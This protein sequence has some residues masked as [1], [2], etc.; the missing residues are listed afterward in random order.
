MK[1]SAA[2]GVYDTGTYFLIAATL[3]QKKKYLKKSTDLFRFEV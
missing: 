3:S 2:K 1:M